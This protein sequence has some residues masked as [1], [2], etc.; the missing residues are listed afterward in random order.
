[1]P[2]TPG[3]IGFFDA[4]IVETPRLLGL[5]TASAVMAA[6]LFRILSFMICLAFGLPGFY[7]FLKR[8]GIPNA[9]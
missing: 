4:V 1:V 8:P 5:D 6:V 9:S 2:I 7:Y 3:S